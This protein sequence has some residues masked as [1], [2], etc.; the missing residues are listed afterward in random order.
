MKIPKKDWCFIILGLRKKLNLSHN[1]L[2]ELLNINRKSIGRYEEGS[3]IPSDSF[4]LKILDFIL[5]QKFNLNKLKKLGIKYYHEV[6]EREKLKPLKLEYSKELA[7]LIGILLGDGEIMRDGTLRISFDPK[8]DKNFLY[9]KVFPLIKNILNNKIG[10]ESYKR[11]SFHN[12]AFVR[13]L[14]EE[15]KLNPGSKFENNSEI[16][17]W[18]FEKEGLMKLINMVNKEIGWDIQKVKLP[19]LWNSQNALFSKFIKEDS[20]Y[21]KSLNIRKQYKWDEISKEL[22]NIYGAEILAKKLNIG[23]RSIRRWRDNSR[24]P[25]V[26]F[27]NNLIKIAN[28]SNL[29][30]EKYKVQFD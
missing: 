6:K 1:K 13:Y 7:E 10:F 11:I 4:K 19:F 27:I 22:I 5:K 16:P 17:K 24:I 9:R 18:C 2:G 21:L 28:K 26:N 15:C 29:D 8:K 23:A 14:R 30:I 12:I 25:S 3:R 20:E